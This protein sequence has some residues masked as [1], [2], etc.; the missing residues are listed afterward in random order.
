MS[1]FCI[2]RASAIIVQ[3]H[4]KFPIIKF[5]KILKH[6]SK[7]VDEITQVKKSFLFNMNQFYTHD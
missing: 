7:H 2:M 3:L 5:G 6:L 4:T 1:D